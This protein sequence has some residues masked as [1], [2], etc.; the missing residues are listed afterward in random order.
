MFSQNITNKP[1]FGCTVGASKINFTRQESILIIFE[2]FGYI[3]LKSILISK[4]DF[5]RSE[6]FLLSVRITFREIIKYK[7]FYLKINSN[8]INSNKINFIYNQFYKR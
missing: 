6:N 8:H 7:S 4:I 1:V 3:P 2:L 5:K